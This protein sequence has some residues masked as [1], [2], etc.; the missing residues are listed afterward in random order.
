MERVDERSLTGILKP[1]GDTYIDTYT[2][3]A[4]CLTYGPKRARTLDI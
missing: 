1:I 2:D 4:C 3:T